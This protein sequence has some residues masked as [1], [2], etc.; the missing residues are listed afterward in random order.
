[1]LLPPPSR[2]A[3]TVLQG[4][5]VWELRAAP[6]KED[7][8]SV[9]SSAAWPVL[10]RA[11]CRWLWEQSCQVHNLWVSEGREGK[12]IPNAWNQE[13]TPKNDTISM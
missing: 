3:P 4:P 8:V 10:G 12:L 9:A 5:G 6:D 2:T 1:M 13:P 11:V 7:G